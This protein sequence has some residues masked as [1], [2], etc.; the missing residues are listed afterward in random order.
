M[1]RLSMGYFDRG[2]GGLVKIE[3]VFKT[4][5]ILHNWL[6][7]EDGLDLVGTK[8]SHWNETSPDQLTARRRIYSLVNG[9]LMRYGDRVVFVHAGTDVSKCGN[10]SIHPDYDHARREAC[11]TRFESTFFNR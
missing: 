6:M 10:Q 9:Q 1:L 2:G 11:P 8:P 7:Q 3:N 5:C 4:C